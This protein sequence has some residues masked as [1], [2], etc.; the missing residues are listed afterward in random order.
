MKEAEVGAGTG[1]RPV[2]FDLELLAIKQAGPV[3]GQPVATK[4][5]SR[6]D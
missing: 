4:A 5:R 2:I 3:G 1:G 6:K